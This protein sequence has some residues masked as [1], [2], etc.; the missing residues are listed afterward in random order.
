MRQ[1]EGEIFG[2]ERGRRGG[3]DI[4][5]GNSRETHVRSAATI[6]PHATLT[7]T[8]PPPHP[9]QSSF[10]PFPLLPIKL[11]TLYG[12]FTLYATY[13]HITYI[14]LCLYY[15]YFISSC[16]QNLPL[17]FFNF[18]P[19]LP[20]FHPQLYILS[21]SLPSFTTLNNTLTVSA[22]SSAVVVVPSFPVFLIL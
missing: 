21:P 20:K 13:T 14:H 7:R 9:P 4:Y 19:I 10:D 3:G 8:P 16:S 6:L 22:Y 12:A 2:R 1:G 5:D 17:L 18:I 11:Y 15:N